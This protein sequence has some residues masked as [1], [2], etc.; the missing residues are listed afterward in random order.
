MFKPNKIRLAIF[1]TLWGVSAGFSHQ[2]IA[3]TE[4]E[5]LAETAQYIAQDQ[6]A[7]ERDVQRLSAVIVTAQY[8]PQNIQEIPSAITAVSGKDLGAK[9]NTFIGDILTYAPNAKAQNT[10]GDSRPRWY[11]RG[12]GTGDVAP[13]T[14]Y[15]VG[16]Y[17]DGV[18]VNPPVTGGGDLFDLE[19]V[20]VLRGPQGTLYGKNTT[21]GAVNF[22]SKK[23]NFNDKPN[24]YI[25]LGL[26]DD[27]LKAFEGAAN[28][29][30]SDQLAIRGSFYSEDRDG[31][32]N[33]IA[34]GKSYGD[35]DKNLI[36]CKSWQS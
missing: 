12:L 17:A 28:A 36:V 23:P 10:D 7:S 3:I 9:G 27:N 2:A 1:S 34:T 33:N 29:K 16:I 8:K 25:T 24:G 15:P 31:F 6:P 14:V 22:V 19:R 5:A 30:I 21:A 35:V 26:G 20:E 4:E 13:S 11:I 18:Y 32:A